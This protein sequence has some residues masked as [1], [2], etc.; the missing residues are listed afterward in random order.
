[1]IQMNLGFFQPEP[2]TE[3]WDLNS[4]EPEQNAEFWNLDSVEPEPDTEFWNLNSFEPEPKQNFVFEPN[5]RLNTEFSCK[6]YFNFRI[7]IL[8]NTIINKGKNSVKFRLK[9][10]FFCQFRFRF[11]RNRIFG[12]Q[13]R[14]GWKGIRNSAEYVISAEFFKFVCTLGRPTK[15]G[16]RV[17][18]N[19]IPLDVLAS[20]L[21]TEKSYFHKI[22][23]I[24]NKVKGT[25]QN[26]RTSWGWAVPS[27]AQLKLTTISAK[28]SYPI[29]RSAY[30]AKA[31][32]GWSH[33]LGWAVTKNI[34][35]LRDEIASASYY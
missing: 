27:S 29:A 19:P 13:V 22:S 12:K 23:I 20:S 28:L 14:F 16:T 31:N 5:I 34:L 26:I 4:V 9:P 11:N 17:L 15:H 10:N 21:M 8:K 24:E 7:L 33:K 6:A 18:S 35:V 32:C 30:S 1:M 2:D 25:K 3:F